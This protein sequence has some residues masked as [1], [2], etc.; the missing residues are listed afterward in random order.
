MDWRLFS[1]YID[2]K[3]I[4]KSSQKHFDK[5]SIN[6]AGFFLFMYKKAAKS[7][8]VYLSVSQ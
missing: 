4:Q 6:K 1:L 2:V 8:Y 3:T 7:D 5:N